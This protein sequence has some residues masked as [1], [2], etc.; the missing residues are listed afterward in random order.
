MGERIKIV[1]EWDYCT[2]L[3]L[4]LRERRQRTEQNETRVETREEKNTWN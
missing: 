4:F 3:F 1:Y 2:F